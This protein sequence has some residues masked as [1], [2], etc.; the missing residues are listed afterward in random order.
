MGGFEPEGGPRAQNLRVHLARLS[1]VP[2]WRRRRA[3]FATARP[4][5]APGPVAAS[6]LVKPTNG[7]IGFRMGCL[8]LA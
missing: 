6:A 3:A 4:S 5:S 7:A 1:S 8:A 2:C